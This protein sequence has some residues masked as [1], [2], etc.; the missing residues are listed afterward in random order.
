LLLF[1]VFVFS[2]VVV[3]FKV[4][5]FLLFYGCCFFKCLF[6]VLWIF[7]WSGLWICKPLG[8]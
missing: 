8:L 4:Y 3:F 6:V 7:L 5:G 1:F 2:E